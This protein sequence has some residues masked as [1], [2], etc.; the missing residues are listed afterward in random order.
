MP[1]KASV[2]ALQRKVPSPTVPRCLL[3]RTLLHSDAEEDLLETNRSTDQRVQHNVLP[4]RTLYPSL[5]KVLCMLF[6][7]TVP[8]A[9]H[10]PA[11]LLLLQVCHPLWAFQGQ[12]TTIWRTKY[13]GAST[14]ILPYSYLTICISSRKLHLDDS[15]SGPMGS[16]V[17][18]VRNWRPVTDSFQKWLTAY[19]VYMLVTL[20]AIQD[21]LSS[22]LSTSR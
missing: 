16:P 8:S 18:M 10:P 17:T 2:S 3:L 9:R 7:Q 20:T 19:M 22:L 12:W 13:S 6:V 1:H 14:L 15:S 11:K 21:R 5:Y 4:F